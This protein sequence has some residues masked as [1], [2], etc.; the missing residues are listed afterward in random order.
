MADTQPTGPLAGIRVLD[1]TRVLSGPFAT[2]IL[3]D[4]GAD[5]VKIEDPA[6]GDDTR[7]WG[8][9]FVETESAYF[10]SVNRNKRSLALDLKSD[11][12][13]EIARALA[14]EVDVVVENFRPGVAARLGLGYEAVRELNPGVI[15][16]SIS[17]YGQDSSES[18]KPGYD[19]IMQARSGL[20]SITGEALGGPARVG[21]ASADIS[22]GMWTAIGT[23]AALHHRTA[24]GRGQWLD[25]SLLDAQVSWLSNVAGAWFASGGVPARYGTGHPSIV[26]SEAFATSDGLLMVA[27]GNDAMWV[28]MAQALGVERLLEDARFATNAHRV[29][30]REELR[31]ELERVL[32]TDTTQAWLERLDAAAVPAARVNS[33][34]EALSDPLLRERDMIV[35]LEHQSV[36]PVRSVGSPVR[37]SETPPSM[38]SAPPVLGQD[39]RAVLTE[40]GLDPAEI[41]DLIDRGQVTAGD[42]AADRAQRLRA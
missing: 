4:L 1:L 12:G 8:P 26:P 35:E 38:R 37:L 29:A 21:V 20:M 23:L 31:G 40:L 39:T 25:L 36:G 3:A 6:R 13:R 7:H 9:P 15:Y 27:A 17:G 16:A 2:M 34:G 22:A 30:H 10:M 11:R 33:I 41:Q 28:R 24:T 14:A 42:P 18:D 32:A 5:V 19:P